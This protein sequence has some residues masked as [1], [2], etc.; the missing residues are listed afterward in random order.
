MK[1][2]VELK[3]F[4]PNLKVGLAS[5]SQ[6]QNRRVLIV[7]NP[8]LK[9]TSLLTNIINQIGSQTVKIYSHVRPCS[10]LVAVIEGSLL[11]KQWQPEVMVIVGD[12]SAISTGRAMRYFYE[13][14]TGTKQLNAILIPTINNDGLEATRKFVI[15]S[16]KQGKTLTYS[17]ARCDS[18]DLIINPNKLD[19][20]SKVA[21]K[22][23]LFE[24]L[25]YG[26]ET[27]ASTAA[28]PTTDLLATNVIKLSF[29][30]LTAN[31]KATN[32]A[33]LPLISAFTG[34]VMD[35]IGVGIS[36]AF[37]ERLNTLFHVPYGMTCAMMIGPILAFNSARCP[38]LVQKYQA[39]REQPDVLCINPSHDLPKTVIGLRQ[40]LE[41]PNTLA[42]F[43]LEKDDIL[44][45]VPEM[46]R[47]IQN[48]LIHQ[49]IPAMPTYQEL[50]QFLLA[51]V[52]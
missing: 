2:V 51:I 48:T 24:Q 32:N 35:Q 44:H 50:N 46:L 47:F 4:I 40:Q 25:S 33:V 5:L 34:N 42:E 8:F 23:A 45:A 39:V 26:L 18:D 43:G 19:E 21:E 12:R 52:N 27:L 17:D 11:I 31:E 49:N 37:A 6:Q 41:F 3:K 38:I 16:G 1:V 28:N 7:C 14:Q 29:Q 9:R 36:Y 15:S 20:L 22:T 13:Q 30:Q 10:P